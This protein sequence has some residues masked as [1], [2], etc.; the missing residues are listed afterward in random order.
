MCSSHQG[1]L[2]YDCF[3]FLSVRAVEFE[4]RP[5]S[6]VSVGMLEHKET[7]KCTSDLS[8]RLQPALQARRIPPSRLSFKPLDSRLL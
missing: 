1:I 4:K 6:Y 8:P 3:Q 5:F 2:Q 7:L